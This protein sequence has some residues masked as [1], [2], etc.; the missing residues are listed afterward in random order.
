MR[1]R[2]SWLSASATSWSGQLA[3]RSRGGIEDPVTPLAL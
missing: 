1:M 3:L 2:A